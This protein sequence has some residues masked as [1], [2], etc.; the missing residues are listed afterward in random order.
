MIIFV[1]SK[2]DFDLSY[3]KKLTNNYKKKGWPNTLKK[4]LRKCHMKTT[5]IRYNWGFCTILLIERWS[6]DPNIYRAK[7][8]R[9]WI[10][11]FS[12]S[13]KS[14]NY[15]EMLTHRPRVYRRASSSLSNA[16]QP[17]KKHM[18]EQICVTSSSLC[19]RGQNT[20]PSQS[21]G[22]PGDGGPPAWRRQRAA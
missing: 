7:R 8:I 6:A 17:Q 20:L 11:N 16:H 2:N 14:I 3:K 22:W 4:Q 5:C 12:I 10:S 15:I 1:C 9:Q 21:P 19:Q 13:S 18:F